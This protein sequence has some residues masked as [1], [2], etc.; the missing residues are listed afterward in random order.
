MIPLK[1]PVIPVVRTSTRDAA[2]TAVELLRAEGF[3][4]FEITLTTPDAI[5]LIAELSQDD[6]LTVGAGTVLEEKQATAAIE[7]GA[8]F[9]VSP[10]LTAGVGSLC[11]QSG[12]AW[13]PGA[14]SPTEIHTA[15][16]AGATGVKIFPAAQLGGPGFLRAVRSVLPNVTLM[17]TGGIGPD[18]I[19][20]YL[21][22][23]AFAVGLGGKLVD[24][25][26]IISGNHDAVSAVARQILELAA[27]A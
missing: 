17:P 9:V 5:N 14:A 4:T 26:A 19:R 6:A 15:H 25:Q 24:E 20:E 7:A 12:T 2:A 16:L 8:Q 3:E 13:F 27:S 23:G 22:A 11:T 10:V 18:D 1:V 21:D